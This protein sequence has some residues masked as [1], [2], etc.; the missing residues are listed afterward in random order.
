[1]LCVVVVTLHAMF[2]KVF[3]IPGKVAYL[4]HVKDFCRM[5][6]SLSKSDISNDRSWRKVHTYPPVS[7]IPS[8]TTPFPCVKD[9]NC[10]IHLLEC[11]ATKVFMFLEARWRYSF[12]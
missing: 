11:T 3:S 9:K 10:I 8:H 5:K 6:Q 1:M 2:L 12:G 7:S 4:A